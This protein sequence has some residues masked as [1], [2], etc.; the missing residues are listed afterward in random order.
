MLIRR[1]VIERV[2]RFRQTGSKV[3]YNSTNFLSR[4]L[5]KKFKIAHIKSV[6]V[7]WNPKVKTRNIDKVYE[8]WKQL[9]KK[10][11]IR[12]VTFKDWIVD[13]SNGKYSNY[14]KILSKMA[15][16]KW[17][18]SNVSSKIDIVKKICLKIK[19]EM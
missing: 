13:V 2:G 4:T 1:D 11:K 3:C 5:Q 15:K 12:N 8:L 6:T 16:T 14:Q 19:M 7:G 18:E 17:I 10:N 9:S